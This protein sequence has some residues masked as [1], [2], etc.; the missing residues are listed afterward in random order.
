M[1][2]KET[3]IWRSYTDGASPQDLV[4]KEIEDRKNEIIYKG[5][6]KEEAGLENDKVISHEK[7]KENKELDNIY[8]EYYDNGSLKLEYE[9]RISK[10]YYQDGKLKSSKEYDENLEADGTW[11]FYEKDGSVNRM[12]V[13]AG[14]E[15]LEISQKEYGTTEIGYVHYVYNG[16][17]EVQRKEYAPNEDEYI[18]V[19]YEDGGAKDIYHERD[20]M[21]FYTR[22]NENDEI[23]AKGT[24]DEEMKKVGDWVTLDK[25]NT[26]TNIK[27]Y[28]EDILI[29]EVNYKNG[30]LNGPMREYDKETG[31]LISEKIFKG[32][33][34]EKLMET[35][36]AAQPTQEKSQG[37]E[38]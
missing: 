10:E 19:Y 26:P 30:I 24:F 33:A 1:E 8:K 7:N 13:Y 25:T 15:L 17:N 16:Y 34:E 5:L 2:E 12:E 14:G 20:G 22:R 31:E 18:K 36:R 29:K 9:N 6:E 3:Y 28:A 4:Y 38:R 23:V 11:K 27:T 32:G 37:I 21:T 35:L